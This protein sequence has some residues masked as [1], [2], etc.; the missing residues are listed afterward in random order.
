MNSWS[1]WL[2]IYLFAL[3]AADHNQPTYYSSRIDGALLPFFKGD[4]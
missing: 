4:N 1:F 3:D 2:A